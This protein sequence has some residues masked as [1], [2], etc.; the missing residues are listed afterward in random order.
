MNNYSIG[1]IGGGRAA[2]IILGGFERAGKL[3]ARIIVS[4][5]NIEGLKALKNEFPE[6]ITV[7]KDKSKAAS[8]DLIFIALHPLVIGEVLREL[9]AFIKPSSIV[10]SLAPKITISTISGL[11]DGNHKIVRMIP[12]APSI[13]NEGYNPVAFSPSLTEIERSSLIDLFNILGDTIQTPEE[14]LEAYAI[15]FAMGP[16]YLWFQL[17]TLQ[18]IGRSFGLSE[19]ELNDGLKKMATG[20][21]NTMYNSGMSPQDVMDLVAVKPLKEYEEE[22]KNIYRKSLDAMY[23]KLKDKV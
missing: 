14:K 4:D 16:T 3:P 23:K 12:N 17:D 15:L 7:E 22:I 1:F 8:Q 19:Q 2:R 21:F 6:I 18:E 11:L 13:I 20:A 5:I 10:I 9:K